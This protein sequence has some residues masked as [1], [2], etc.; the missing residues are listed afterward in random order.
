MEIRT[1]IFRTRKNEASP[2]PMAASV[3]QYTAAGGD[4]QEL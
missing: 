4:V 3:K 1:K 2:T